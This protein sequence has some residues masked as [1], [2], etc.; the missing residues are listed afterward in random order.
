MLLKWRAAGVYREGNSTHSN[1]AAWK[2]G[3]GGKRAPNR[4][5]DSKSSS[6]NSKQPAAADR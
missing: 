2:G 3:G 5:T 1:L 6:S 4:L